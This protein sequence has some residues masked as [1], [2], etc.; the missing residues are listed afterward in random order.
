MDRI[1]FLLEELSMQSLLEGLLPRIFPRLQFACIPH[2]GKHD[3]EKSIPRKLRAWREPGVSFVVVRDN[4]T[5]N[6]LAAKRDLLQRCREG[7]REDTLVRMVC[8]EL[9]AWHIGEPDALAEAFENEQL[10]GIGNQSRFRDPD[11]IAKPSDE[12]KQLVRGFSK[13]RGA[14]IMSNHLTRERNCSRSFAVFLDGIERLR[15]GVAINEAESLSLNSL[16]DNTTI[17][18]GNSPSPL[19]PGILP[20]QPRMMDD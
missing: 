7:G 10:R 9:E 2:E 19:T 3:L 5:G 16:D 15:P 1:I 4:D 18:E 6:C 17:G 20:Y 13:N 11:A 12:V 8:Q 14:R